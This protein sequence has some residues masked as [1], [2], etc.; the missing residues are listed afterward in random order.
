MSSQLPVPPLNDEDVLAEEQYVK[1]PDWHRKLLDEAIAR[2]KEV[3][4]EGTPWEEVDKEM[5]EYLEE[6]KNRKRVK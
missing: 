2:Y 3:G 5:D 1:I 6:L 4:I